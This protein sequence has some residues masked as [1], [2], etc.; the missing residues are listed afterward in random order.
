M[1]IK[2]G[3]KSS[4]TAW[5]P[6]LMGQT[7]NFVNPQ[8]HG[9]APRRIWYSR[10][11]LFEML[12]FLVWSTSLLHSLSPAK[13]I[14]GYFSARENR[15]PSMVGKLSLLILVL[16]ARPRLPREKF[17]DLFAFPNCHTFY[18]K[19]FGNLMTR[20]ENEEANFGW[21]LLWFVLFSS[22]FCSACQRPETSE[23]A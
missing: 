2:R 11:G 6:T 18:G 3:A 22:I 7:A 17:F 13:V 5:Q 1:S 20:L 8:K 14:I 21:W 19:F 23:K 10:R 12:R 15:L 4:V 16:S 9:A